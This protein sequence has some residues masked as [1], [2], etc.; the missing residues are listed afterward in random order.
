MRL[1]R[2][3]TAPFSAGGAKLTSPVKHNSL[4]ITDIAL[5]ER[6]DPQG[7]KKAH[8]LLA[9][10]ETPNDVEVTLRINFLEI[11]QQASPATDQQQ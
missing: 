4:P 11:V 9:D 3:E 2:A 1:G 8:R 10:V 7:Q 6:A 5:A